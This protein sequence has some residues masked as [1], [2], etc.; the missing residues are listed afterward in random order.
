MANKLYDEIHIQAIADA[1]RS[2]NGRSDTYTVSQM[3]SAIES[4]Q[5]GTV[6]ANRLAYTGTITETVVGSG[7]YAVLVKDP[8][9]AE[10][11]SNENLFVRVDFDIEPTAYTIKRSWAQN[12]IGIIPY[13]STG[14]QYQFIFRFDSSADNGMQNSVYKIFDNTQRTS[15]TGR[16]YITEDGE[17]QIYSNSGSNYAIRPSNYTV[18]VEW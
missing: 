11:R 8:L 9:L 18:T 13:I 1:I 16:L 15:G 10:L 17:L 12:T 14:E 4:I 2:K 5:T 3:P 7:A 6:E